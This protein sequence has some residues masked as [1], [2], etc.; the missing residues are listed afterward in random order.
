M[1]RL[2]ACLYFRFLPGIGPVKEQ[3]L[4]THFSTPEAIFEASDKEWNA[5]EGIGS[6][7]FENHS[8]LETISKG[9]GKANHINKKKADSSFILG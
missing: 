3:K 4:L 9:R 1:N 7:F 6:R 2:E 5:L 8:I